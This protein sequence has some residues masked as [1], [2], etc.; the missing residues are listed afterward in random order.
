MHKPQPARELV[1]ELSEQCDRCLILYAISVPARAFI[2][3]ECS[4][5]GILKSLDMGE[6]DAPRLMRIIIGQPVAPIASAP[7]PIVYSL[8]VWPNYDLQKV[9]SWLEAWP[10]ISEPF[11]SAIEEIQ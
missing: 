5:F 11:E 8:H 9:R 2:K 4:T 1:I 6:G 10:H 7:D 3:V